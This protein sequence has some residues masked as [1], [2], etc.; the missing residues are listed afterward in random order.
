[1]SARGIWVCGKLGQLGHVKLYRGL[2]LLTVARAHASATCAVRV[3][4]YVE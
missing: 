4:V 2:W 3:N 1:M